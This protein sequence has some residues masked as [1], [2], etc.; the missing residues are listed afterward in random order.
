M[1]MRGPSEWSVGDRELM[2]AYVSEMN[3]CEFCVKAHTA[4][5]ARA[6]HDKGAVSEVLGNLHAADIHDP[7]QATLGLLGKLTREH[8]VDEDDMGSLLG[9]G[10]SREQIEDALAVCFAFN[11]VT[12]TRMLSG[13]RSPTRK[14]LMPARSTFSPAATADP[15]RR[16]LGPSVVVARSGR[17]VGGWTGA[18]QPPEYVI[19]GRYELAEVIRRHAFE[20]HAGE[21]LL[22][23][24]QGRCDGAAFLGQGDDGRAPVG[25]ARLLQ[26][27]EDSW[28]P[29]PAR[30][31]LAGDE[32]VFG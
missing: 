15:R 9:A 2:A 24:A 1:R 5:A 21:G 22:L 6:Y 8:T 11:T 29:R 17:L 3:D 18:A 32:P 16:C 12:D 23:L 26:P 30:V 10:V 20:H 13:S 4:V 27:G 25:G 28:R 7:L 19:K 31:R 14:L